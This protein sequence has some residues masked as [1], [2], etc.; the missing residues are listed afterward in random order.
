MRQT[1]QIYLRTNSPYPEN[2][3]SQ[4]AESR[5]A[6]ELMDSPGVGTQATDIHSENLP[7]YH[8]NQEP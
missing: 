8:L 3:S 5:H 6:P 7:I 1:I 2:E 4:N